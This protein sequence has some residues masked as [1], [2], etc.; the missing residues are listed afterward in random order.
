MHGE[1][2]P[3]LRGARGYVNMYVFVCGGGTHVVACQTSP[4][5]RESLISTQC[6][7]SWLGFVKC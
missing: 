6:M 5:E 4:Q 7:A 1:V 2:G 3:R